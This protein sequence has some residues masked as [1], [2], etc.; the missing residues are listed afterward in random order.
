MDYLIKDLEFSF[1]P[2]DLE[3]RNEDL[4]EAGQKKEIRELVMLS[5]KGTMVFKRDGKWY[6][7]KIMMGYD[8]VVKENMS[9]DIEIALNQYTTRC[10]ELYEK[11]DVSDTSGKWSPKEWSWE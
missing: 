4:E 3:E 8:L 6:S 10:E 2:V 9:K 1:K 7:F 11:L 5:V